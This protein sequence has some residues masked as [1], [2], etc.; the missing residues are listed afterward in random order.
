MFLFPFDKCDSSRLSI[1][2][3]IYWSGDAE[4]LAKNIGLCIEDQRLA[5]GDAVSVYCQRLNISRATYLRLKSGNP[6]VAAGAL[7][8]WCALMGKGSS[9]IEVFQIK[10]VFERPRYKNGKLIKR[11]RN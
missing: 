2:M 3:S 8:E 6:G 1:Y 5:S 11:I 10:R 4:Q 9:L 7:F